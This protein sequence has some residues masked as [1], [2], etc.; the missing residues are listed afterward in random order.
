MSFSASG[1]AMNN[2][3]ASALAQTI[4]L[5]I[6]PELDIKPGSKILVTRQG[7][8]TAYRRTGE[9]ELHSNHQEIVLDLFDG[10]A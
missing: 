5:F 8:T 9:P 10:W 7:K 4:K 1:A 6:A 2:G 3:S